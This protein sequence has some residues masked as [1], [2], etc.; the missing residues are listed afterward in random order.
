MT[1]P[2]I[3]VRESL[4][5]Q[6]DHFV[7]CIREGTRP[8]TDGNVG[9]KVV[10]VLEQADV[11][12]QNGGARIALIDDQPLATVQIG[13]HLMKNGKNGVHELILAS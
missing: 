2:Y 5:N 8:L 9:R 1:I 12:L 7:E 11:S 3:P 4:R 13:G 10:R 6:C